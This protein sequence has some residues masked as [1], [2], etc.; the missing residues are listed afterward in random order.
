MKEENKNVKTFDSVYQDLQLLLG[1]AFPTIFEMS[2]LL[3]LSLG[4]DCKT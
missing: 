1:L 2:K 3:H 4:H